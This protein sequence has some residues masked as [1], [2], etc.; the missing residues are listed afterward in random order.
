MS[1]EFGTL[2]RNSLV[3]E[4]ILEPATAMLVEPRPLITA[5]DHLSV[6]RHRG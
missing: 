2:E 4:Y 3:S 5:R 6:R 1:R